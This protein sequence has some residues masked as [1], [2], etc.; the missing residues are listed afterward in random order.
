MPL[1]E[2]GLIL[3]VEFRKGLEDESGRP[4]RRTEIR[5]AAEKFDGAEPTEPSVAPKTKPRSYL[6]GTTNLLLFRQA[7]VLDIGAGSSP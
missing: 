4:C 1:Q 7:I 2:Q 5:H 6:T 3:F